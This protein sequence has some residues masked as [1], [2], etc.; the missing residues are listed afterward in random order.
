MTKRTPQIET[1][2]L[3]GFAA[4]RSLLDMCQEHGI[5]PMTFYNWRRADEDL[6]HRYEDAQAVHADAL[7]DRAMRI[8]ENPSSDWVDVRAGAEADDREHIRHARL[9]ID[10]SLRIARIHYR[11]H[12]A[13]NARRDREA[14]REEK[15][16]E[17]EAEAGTERS[18]K[19]AEPYCPD[20]VELLNEA[21]ARFARGEDPYIPPPSPTIRPSR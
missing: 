21:H 5:A 3:D 1:A 8:A 9:R 7:I 17:A 14:E 6:A 10:I 15:E 4:G 16:A 13:A 11:R 18:L 2:I 12:D 20:L 19:P